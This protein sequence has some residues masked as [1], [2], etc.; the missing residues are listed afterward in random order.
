LGTRE[1]EEFAEALYNMLHGKQQQGFEAQVE[2]L[3]RKKLAKWTLLTVI[4]SYSKPKRDLLIKP[5]TVKLIID[6]L[7]LDL[8]YKPQP[9]WN[10]YSKYRT[11][12]NSMRKLVDPTLAPSNTAFCGFLMSEL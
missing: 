9:T 2:L 1:Q 8:E 3:R 5:S 7:E 6:K 12:I 4:P 10:F 11:Q